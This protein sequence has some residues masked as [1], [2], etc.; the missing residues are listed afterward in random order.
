MRLLAEGDNLMQLYGWTI[1]YKSHPK[2]RLAFF[3]FRLVMQIIVMRDLQLYYYSSVS[4]D[5]LFYT[6]LAE[7]LYAIGKRSPWKCKFLTTPM[8]INQIPYVIFQ[9]INQFFFKN[10]IT[11]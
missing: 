5:Q 2:I 3:V 9:T 7:T 8:K 4:S 1:S 6:F 10:C 11:L